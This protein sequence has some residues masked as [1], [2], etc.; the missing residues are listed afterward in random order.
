MIS[1]NIIK[2]FINAIGNE[3]VIVDPVE[4]AEAEKT[5]YSTTNKI[6]LILRPST[7]EEVKK[8]V[9]LANEFKI[10]VYPVSKG[11]NWGYGSSFR[12][13]IIIF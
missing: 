3:Y 4:R 12:L 8:C 9:E 2:S 7:T 1:E 13:L 11:K 5:N 10:P 6:P